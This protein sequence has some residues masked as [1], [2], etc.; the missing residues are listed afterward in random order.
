MG[1]LKQDNIIVGAWLLFAIR[2]DSSNV[3]PSIALEKK[4]PWG[5]IWLMVENGMTPYICIYLGYALLW[6]S[7]LLPSGHHTMETII[8]YPPV[9]E[10]PLFSV[11]FPTVILRPLFT[12]STQL[13][14]RVFL[15]PAK[16]N[17]LS[18]TCSSPPVTSRYAS[19]VIFRPV[20]F[21]F[22]PPSRGLLFVSFKQYTVH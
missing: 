6:T 21:L 1:E 22:S 18:L 19:S 14:A 8:S 17:S 3:Y 16:N 15:L 13:Q 9:A 20:E 12:N 7:I 5:G 11:Q 2:L 10:K 4:G